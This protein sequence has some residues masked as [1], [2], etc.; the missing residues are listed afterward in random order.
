[1]YRFRRLSGVVDEV[2]REHARVV[3][4]TRARAGKASRH[5]LAGPH[6][7]RRGDYRVICRIRRA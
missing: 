4:R 1:M 7:A 6:S 2:E 5:V 3:M